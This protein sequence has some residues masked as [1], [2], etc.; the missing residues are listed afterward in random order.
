[1]GVG[2]RGLG[3]NCCWCCCYRSVLDQAFLYLM[4]RCFKTLKLGHK[5]AEQLDHS[6]MQNRASHL[7]YSCMNTRTA[8]TPAPTGNT[9]N[10]YSDTLANLAVT[11]D[12]VTPV[13]RAPNRI[14]RCL[15]TLLLHEIDID[16]EASLE[17][18]QRMMQ[19]WVASPLCRVSICLTSLKGPLGSQMLS[20]VPKCSAMLLGFPRSICSCP[21]GREESLSLPG[22][23]SPNVLGIGLRT[24]DRQAPRVPTFRERL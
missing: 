14:T 2:C 18:Q 12:A 1:M 7:L 21:K 17:A 6:A 16:A 15:R 19:P 3:F 24:F 23:L 10:R 5:D 13:A 4:P 20:A 22:T 8:H 9:V 11:P